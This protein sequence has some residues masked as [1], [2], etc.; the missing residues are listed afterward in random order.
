MERRMFLKKACG[1]CVLASTGILVNALQSC[2]MPKNLV[3]VEKK[4]GKLALDENLFLTNTTILL[5]TNSWDY[6]IAVS[7]CVDGSFVAVEMKC[8]H[9]AESLSQTGRGFVCD[10]H[11]SVFDTQGKVQK[12]PAQRNLQQ[13]RVGRENNQIVVHLSNV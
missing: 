13:F 8:S 9:Y 11:G 5:R 12:G 2:N 10:A 7:K 4:D 6:D 1:V 3:K